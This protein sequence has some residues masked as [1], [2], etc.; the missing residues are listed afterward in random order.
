V[1]LAQNKAFPVIRGY[2]IETGPAPREFS[3]RARIARGRKDPSLRPL[4]LAGLSQPSADPVFIRE[5]GKGAELRD[6]QA[7][8]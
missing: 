5:I 8:Q 3:P 4:L 1:T 7:A 2:N 6:E